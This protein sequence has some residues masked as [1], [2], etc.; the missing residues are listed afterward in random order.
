MSGMKR[1]I[2]AAAVVA[3]FSLLAGGCM[4]LPTLSGDSI[5]PQQ[6]MPAL[7]APSYQEASP[8]SEERLSQLDPSVT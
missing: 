5:P 7:V 4:V 6:V 8:P 1:R 3:S 2:A